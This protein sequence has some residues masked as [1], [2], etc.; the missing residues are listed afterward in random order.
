MVDLAREAERAGLDSVWAAEGYYARDA[1]TS[2][3]AIAAVTE[4]V[5]LGTGVVPVFTRHPALLA[6]SFASLD[7]L[8]NGRAIVGI[9]SGERDTV[10]DQL[11]YD[12]SRPLAAMREAVQIIRGMLAGETLT[13][14]GRVFRA[15]GVRL[16][17]K[18]ARRRPPIYVAAVG[19]KM[20]RLAGEVADGV[21]YPQTSPVFV[22]EANEHV[23]AGA[24]ATGREPAEIDRA[25]MIIC[26]VADDGEAAREIPKPLLAALLAVPEGEHILEHNGLDPSRAVAIRETLASQGMRAAIQH[27]SREMVEILTI[28]GTPAE[29]TA[30]LQSFAA[31]GV[32]HA[33]L[34][35]IG[36]HAEQAIAVAA[37]VRKTSARI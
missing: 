23:D 5:L 8:S 26:S 9:G 3:C 20:C 25:A 19:P 35:A 11:G 1:W 21:Y 34:S 14:E 15:Q 30:K 18:P 29:A 32:T 17:F 16:V 37:E 36:P 4:R 2:L 10:G 22:R 6:M 27:V 7:E 12:F 28:S 24:R 33:V 13:F 31:A